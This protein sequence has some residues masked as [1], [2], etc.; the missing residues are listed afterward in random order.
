MQRSSELFQEAR[1]YLPGGVDSPV[2]AFGSVGGHPFFVRKGS[3]SRLFDEDGNEYIDYVCSWGPLI[4]GHAHPRVVKAVQ[5]AAENGLT[6]GA[7]CELETTLAKM[8]AAAMPSIEMVRFVSS[9][10]E[11]VMS[12]LRVARAFTGRSKVIKFAGCYHG[13]SDSLLVKAGSGLA[14]LGLP[15]SPGVPQSWTRETLVAR[16]NSLDSV[17]RLFAANEKDIAAV[18]VEPVAAN[19]GVVWPKPGFLADLRQLTQD[20]GAV[21]IFDE[22]ITGFRVSYGGAQAL[23]D[24]MPDL[25]CLGKVVGGGLPVGA[26]GGKREIME[27][28]APSGAVYQAGTLAGN[29]VAMSAGIETLKVLGEGDPYGWLQKRTEGLTTGLSH[30]ISRSGVPAFVSGIGSLFTVFFSRE[31]VSDYDSA[32]RS[33]TKKYGK[34]FWSML[35]LGVYMPP[36]QFEA[37]FVSLAHTEPDV[38]RTL[39]ATE[40]ALASLAH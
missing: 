32:L 5:R 19:M 26:Y 10:T 20:R 24:V 7:P 31:E 1:R 16:Y 28:V 38:E 15:S 36:S 8:V 40:K 23:F 21:L 14:T 35:E 30:L 37:C 12:A 6:Y 9:G 29:P 25:T 13:H 11:A 39:Q 27:M 22:V 17:E 4:L 33:D 18:I 2:R 3:G 34:F